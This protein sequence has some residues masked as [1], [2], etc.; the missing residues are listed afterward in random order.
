MPAITIDETIENTVPTCIQKH[1][2]VLVSLFLIFLCTLLLLQVWRVYDS[3]KKYF[4]VEEIHVHKF[5]YASSKAGQAARRSSRPKPKLCRQYSLVK[6]LQ[7][8]IY[9][10]PNFI[11]STTK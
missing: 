9:V 4:F 5:R 7:M 10:V 8:L 6:S 11:R 2:V 3:A 1:D